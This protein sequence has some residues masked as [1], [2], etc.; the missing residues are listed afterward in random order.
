M[1][2]LPGNGGG[3]GSIFLGT[4]NGQKINSFG[5]LFLSFPIISPAP[6]EKT[7]K[8]TKSD[9]LFWGKGIR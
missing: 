1:I 9:L 2:Q 3:E 5:I 7:G 6:G 4:E 8:G